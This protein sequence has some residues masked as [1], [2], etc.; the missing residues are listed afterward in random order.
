[1]SARQLSVCSI[2]N[3]RFWHRLSLSPRPRP[4][5][6]YM[7]RLNLSFRLRYIV[8]FLLFLSGSHAW[9]QPLDFLK[10][11]TSNQNK[12][13]P[14]F[15]VFDVKGHYG[16]HITTGVPVLEET[17]EQN[18][19]HVAEFRLGVKSYGSKRWQQLYRYPTYGIG[20]YQAWFNPQN[21]LLGNPTSVFI[22]FN[23]SLLGKEKI[24]FGIDFETGFSFNFLNYD[25]VDNPDQIAVG[26]A[27]NIHFQL[28]AEASFRIFE[29]LDGAAGMG[30]THFSNGRI[31]TPQRGINLYH[32]FARLRYHMPAWKGKNVNPEIWPTRRPEN[33]RHEMPKF[34]GRWEYYGVLSGGM[35]TPEELW[36]DRSIKYFVGSLSMDVARHYYYFGK[37]GVG[38]DIFHDRSMTEHY[39]HTLLFPDFV[40]LTFLGFHLSHELMINR[41][42][43]VTQV[44]VTLTHR[45]IEGKWYGRWGMRIDITEHFFF[46]GTLKTPAG[47]KADFIELG[48]G[49][50]FYSPKI[51]Y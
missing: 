29:S 40:D 14:K 43:L 34:K 17:I 21:N 13:Y 18:P 20:L 27:L 9:S 10:S 31:R 37:A 15:L 44:G 41:F 39:R 33:I 36:A 32:G 11:D 47:F 23:P 25:P 4:R 5:L 24:S 51:S 45:D 16:R 22:F 7:P 19:Y 42:T 26:S 28:E 12:T 3:F 2:S 48:L 6:K 49:Y 50:N 8:S 1:M 35:V 38:F 46:R 30:F